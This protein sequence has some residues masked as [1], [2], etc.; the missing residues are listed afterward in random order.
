MILARPAAFLNIHSVPI[1]NIDFGCMNAA[2]EK[3]PVIM[4][5]SILGKSSGGVFDVG[6]GLVR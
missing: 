3:S 6:G 4:D 2:D 5:G 1:I